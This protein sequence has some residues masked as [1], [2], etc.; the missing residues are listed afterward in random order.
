MKRKML[1]H[2]Y[3]HTCRPAAEFP[4]VVVVDAV[5]F[6]LLELREDGCSVLKRREAKWSGGLWTVIR[7]LQGQS[8]NAVHT[9]TSPLPARI[10]VFLHE[11]PGLFNR[12][13]FDIVHTC[14]HITL[15]EWHHQ[16]ICVSVLQNSPPPLHYNCSPQINIWSPS[17]PPLPQA[18]ILAPYLRTCPCPS[19]QL[20]GRCQFQGSSFQVGSITPRLTHLLYSG[21]I[22][23][24]GGDDLWHNHHTWL[25]TLFLVTNLETS[26]Q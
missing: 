15:K 19:Y 17:S 23:S 14:Q 18:L 12:S 24:R 4:S 13:H 16:E 3:I 7:M 6:S 21:S 5:S 1:P 10:F 2:F 22:S 8:F 11:S 20:I 9:N 26:Q 25:V